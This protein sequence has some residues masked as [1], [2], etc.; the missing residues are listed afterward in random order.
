MTVNIYGA[1]GA[2]INVVSRFINATPEEGMP[3]IFP[4]ALDAS[5]SNIRSEGKF[6]ASSVFLIPDTDGSGK[7]RRENY[8]VMTNYIPKVMLKFKPAEYNIVVFSGGGGSGSV[9]GPLMVKAIQEAGHAVV[10]VVIGC[11]GNLA[12]AKNNYDTLK[13]LEGISDLNDTVT[14]MSYIDR[15]TMDR[16]DAAAV[17]SISCLLKLFSGKIEGMDSRDVITWINHVVHT[18]MGGRV[19]RLHIATQEE[20]MVDI[21][22]T[23]SVVSIYKDRKI[24]HMKIETLYHS[25]GYGLS[26][27]NVDQLHYLLSETEANCLL[28]EA[29]SEYTRF[30]ELGESAVRVKPKLSADSAGFSF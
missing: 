14:A 17:S 3:D 27:E 9:F 26:A 8:E 12:E 18:G 21:D 20:D 29:E 16:Q 28:K 2:G 6:P 4:I 5:D 1:G 24:D 7:H 19:N 25:I 30:K 13:T 11:G 22:D 15:N 10:C 23:I